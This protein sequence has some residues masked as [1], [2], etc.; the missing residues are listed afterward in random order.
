MIAGSG[1]ENRITSVSDSN[2]GCMSDSILKS[3]KDFLEY[4]KWLFSH[5][6]NLSLEEILEHKE[7][8]FPIGRVGV[9][10]K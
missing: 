9:N 4:E 8:L 7:E 10:R 1:N 3:E 6:T 5:G 2:Y